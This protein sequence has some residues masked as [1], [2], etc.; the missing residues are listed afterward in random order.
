MS[1]DLL[2]SPPRR[3]K[4]SIN[5]AIL[6]LKILLVCISRRLSIVEKCDKVYNIKNGKIHEVYYNASNNEKREGL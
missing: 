1:I 4:R 3:R 5:N 6:K 2:D